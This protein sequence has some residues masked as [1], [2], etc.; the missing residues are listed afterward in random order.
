M[1]NAKTQNPWQVLALL[2]FLLAM[3]VVCGHLDS[4]APGHPATFPGQFGGFAAVVG[5]LIISGYSIAHSIDRRPHGFYRRRVLRIYPL[6]AAAIFFALTPFLIA[7]RRVINVGEFDPSF[8]RVRVFAQNLLMLQNFTGNTLTCDPPLWTLP[9]EFAWYLTAPLLARMRRGALAAVAGFSAIA[10]FVFAQRAAAWNPNPKYGLGILFLGWAWVGGFFL[11]H[12][13]RSA[14]AGTFVVA[15]TLLMTAFCGKP[16]EPWG[17]AT[18]VVAAVLV[19]LAP[20]ISM[21][22]WIAAACD[23][24]GDVSYPLY[25]VHVPSMLVCHVCGIHNPW[26]LLILSV[27]SS[28]VFLGMDARLKQMIV[29]RRVSS[30]IIPTPA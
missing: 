24:L 22:V 27:A 1:L 17:P 30:D 26:V 3:I 9:I 15:I 13:R 8:P 12:N 11:Y 18:A 16:E 4:F 20:K 5:F 7:H 25:L 29:S 10:F 21:P 19:I 2:R 23:F 28:A 14:T 6:Y